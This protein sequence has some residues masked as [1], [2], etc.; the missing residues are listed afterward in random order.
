[1]TQWNY[2][3][4]LKLTAEMLVTNNIAIDC[5]LSKV[6]AALEIPYPNEEKEHIN[7][8]PKLKWLLHRLSYHMQTF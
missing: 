8:D 5:V 4:T 3:E 1:M 2:N 7:F 6:V